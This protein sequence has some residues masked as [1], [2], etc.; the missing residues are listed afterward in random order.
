MK[1]KKAA[2]LC[3]KIKRLFIFNKVSDGGELLEQ[4]IGD[5]HAAYRLAGIPTLDTDSA[6]TIFDVPPDKRQASRCTPQPRG[7]GSAS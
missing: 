6:L 5:G 2:A 3:G 1:L 7:T 4:W